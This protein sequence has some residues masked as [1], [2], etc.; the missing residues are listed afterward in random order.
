MLELRLNKW[1][2]KGGVNL[3]SERFHHRVLGALG[4]PR[5]SFAAAVSGL[6]SGV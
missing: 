5:H 3:R 4:A 1:R 6:S 2:S